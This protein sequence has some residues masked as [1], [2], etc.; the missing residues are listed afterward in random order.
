AAAKRARTPAP[1][2]L[3]GWSVGSGGTG[4]A[5]A[6][7]DQ[8]LEPLQGP[9]LGA[10]PAR[11]CVRGRVRPHAGDPLPACRAVRALASRQATARVPLR[12]A[13]GHAPLR[14][15]ARLRRPRPWV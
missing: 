14:A 7:G 1:A 11:A 15:G 3:G 13:G 2:R 10:A 8:P 4:A 6:R 12:P 9:E 5:P